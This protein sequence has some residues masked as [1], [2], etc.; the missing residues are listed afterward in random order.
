MR[1]RSNVNQNLLKGFKIKLYLTED[2]KNDINRIFQLSRAVYNIGLDMQNKSYESGNG[3]IQFYNMVTIFSDLRN[4]SEMKWLQDISINIIRETLN[5]LDNAF[6]RFFSK[7]NRYP[8]FK[9]RKRSKRSFST[10]SDRTHIYENYVSI[11]GLKD[12]MVLIKSH[13]IPINARLWNPTVSFDGLNYWFSACYETESKYKNNIPNQDHPIGIDV[14]VVNMIVTSDNDVYKYSDW[15]KYEKRKRRLDK[16]LSKDYNKYFQESLDTKT[17]YEDI[18]KSKNHYKRLQ[19]RYKTI[20]KISNKRI[21]DIHTATKRIVD[22]NPTA[23]I[24][25]NISVREQM[26]DRYMKKY[27][28]YMCFYEIHRQLKY[29]AA[30]R[31]IPVIIAEKG[32]PSSQICS[33]CGYKGYIKHRVF[34]CSHCGYKED[35]DL[36]ASY[37]LRNL[38]YSFQRNDA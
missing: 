17:K 10:R 27:S 18:Q 7:Q 26:K 30:D 32:Y 19:K 5:N 25:E 9:S 24:I 23:I 12:R 4:H 20:F 31:N 16:R 35:R 21:N 29:K 3:Y 8:K 2:Q 33:N 13:N 38:Y 36:N 1:K 34:K 14:G 28:P 11:S 6:S 22:S 37:N 15:S